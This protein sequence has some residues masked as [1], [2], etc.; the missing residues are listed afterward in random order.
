MKRKNL[1]SAVLISALLIGTAGCAKQPEGA[2]KG[3][4]KQDKVEL[5]FM[6][7]NPNPEREKAF[8]NMIGKFNEENPSIK[9]IYESVPWDQSHN[10]LVT[11]GSAGNLPDV[12]LMHQQW[13]P[14][15]TSAEWVKPLDDYIEKWEY[16]DEILPY[17]KNVLMDYDQKDTYGYTFGMPDG[18]TLHG[19]FVR[20]DWMEEAGLSREDLSTW[21][22]V[23]DAAE[24][25]TVPEKNQYG[26]AYRGA[27]MGSE[28]MG[29]YLLA[30]LGGK[31]YEDDGTC[32]I[33]TPEGLE[34]FQRYCSLYLDGYSPKDSINWGY[35]EMVQGFTSGL[36]GI[37][38]QTTE[39]SATCKDTMD[40]SVWT[41]LPFPRMSD[42]NIYCKADGYY[43]TM[44]NNTKHPDE[45]W[46][47]ISYMLTP[48]HNRD[49]CE[50]NYTIPV[51]KGAEEDPRFAE[52][53]LS[54]FLDGLQDDHFVREPYYGYFPELAE[55]QETIYDNEVQKYL[56]GQQTA[57][58][59]IKNISDFLTNA[60]Q[61]YM[62]ENPDAPI[63]T[64]V[65]INGEELQ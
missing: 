59:S 7:I 40:D 18:M 41:V 65:N 5:R 64:S 37:M 9:V 55:F 56:L 35:S 51:M 46:E 11:L 27:R 16:K 25:M 42:G 62:K 15:F 17:V 13:Q 29:M 3:E 34:A 24:K 10:K 31:L 60:Q 4:G 30:A 49:I 43:M 52:G 58:E 63:P 12:F 14:E 45:A 57:E 53:P 26:F 38:N 39:V 47:F 33:D 54:G 20:T 61:K 48:E 22:G 2:G 32:R 28:Q 44:S 21:D 36:S 23:F 1:I 19:L 50:A 8:Q 6:D